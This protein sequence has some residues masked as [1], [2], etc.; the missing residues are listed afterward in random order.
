MADRLAHLLALVEAGI[1]FT[2]QED[3]V[4]ITPADLDAGLAALERDLAETLG[5]D[6]HT[7]REAEPVAVL[8]GPPNAGK[9]TLFNALLGRPRAVV[10]DR[11]GTT[12][13]AIDIRFEKDGKEF[14]IVDFEGTPTGKFMLSEHDSIQYIR[15]GRLY[16][17]HRSPDRGNSIRI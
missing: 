5:S 12:R 16:T 15:N 6:D 8:A 14:V 11:P 17:L 4:A 1:D 7:T 13:D 10:A 9:S 3:V 2:D